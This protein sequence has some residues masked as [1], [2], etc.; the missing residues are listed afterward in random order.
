ME[1]IRVRIVEF[2]DRKHYQMQ[3]CDPITRRKRTR[4]TGI[5]R[6]GRKKERT[7]AERVAAVWQAELRENRYQDASKI[8]WED[9]RDRYE[10]EVLSSLAEGTDEKVSGVFNLLE[11]IIN[12]QKLRDLTAERISHFQAKL[13]E[14]GRAES[15]IAGYLA[16]VKAALRWGVRMGMIPKAPDIQRPK[17]A[18]GK[19]TMKGRPVRLE[20]L[21]PFREPQRA[22][23]RAGARQRAAG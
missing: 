11:R 18:K 10:N 8:T 4:S 14:G 7:E 6:T 13:R 17:R 3:Y 16:H 15:N 5:E 21:C 9:F 1:N 12:P 2:G 19:S 23:A 20:E 22:V